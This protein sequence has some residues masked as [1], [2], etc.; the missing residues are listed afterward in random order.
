MCCSVLQCVAVVVLNFC[1]NDVDVAEGVHKH[2]M[3]CVLQSVAVRCSVIQCV[4]VSPRDNKFDVAEGVHKHYMVC[5]LQCLHC[6]A[7]CC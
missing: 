2:Y 4:A 5:V 3:V 6:V 1:D 7:V